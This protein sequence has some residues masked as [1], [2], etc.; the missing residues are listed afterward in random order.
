MCWNAT[1]SLNT[2]FIAIFAMTLAYFNNYP[3]SFY[4][5]A[6]FMSFVS[7]QLLE[8]FI[9]LNINDKNMNK[10]LSIIGLG[11]ILSQPFFSILTINKHTFLKK[12]LIV[13]YIILV[14]IVIYIGYNYINFKSEK[15]PNGHLHWYWLDELIDPNGKFLIIGI[16]W[17]VFLLIP[18]F[19]FS[20]NS[21]EYYKIIFA[22]LIIILSYYTYISQGTAGSMWC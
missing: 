1:V 16:I 15:A 8:A 13:L 22:L 17:L 2:F 19:L 11:L 5:Y 20:I 4:D 9:W 14:A 7:M 6:F 21:K 3:Y 18:I 12:W 10:I